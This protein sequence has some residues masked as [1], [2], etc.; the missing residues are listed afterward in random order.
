MAGLLNGYRPIGTPTLTT[1]LDQLTRIRRRPRRGLPVP[2]FTASVTTGT[3]MRVTDSTTIR[4][5]VRTRW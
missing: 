5:S 1:T 2:R 3:S 4:T